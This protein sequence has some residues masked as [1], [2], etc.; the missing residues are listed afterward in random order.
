MI[1]VSIGWGGKFE[2]PEADVVEGLV[3]DAESLVRVLHQL[4]DGERGI[5]R[6]HNRVRDL[7]FHNKN[8]FVLVPVNTIQSKDSIYEADSN[9]KSPK[10][11]QVEYNEHKHVHFTDLNNT[12]ILYTVVV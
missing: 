10:M 1:E 11:I 4:V 2:S 3:V 5:V 7:R 9:L 8:M 6:L 12:V